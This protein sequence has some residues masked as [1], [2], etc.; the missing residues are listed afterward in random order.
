[1]RTMRAFAAERVE[2][3]KYSRRVGDPD[4]EDA[5]GG[6]SGGG[7]AAVLDGGSVSAAAPLRDGG[8][9]GGG[10]R[11]SRGCRGCGG[12]P[13]WPCC[14]ESS[15]LPSEESSY[16]LGVLKALGYGAFAGGMSLM[17]YASLLCVLW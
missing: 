8:R 12:C 15:W 3:L 10:S 2:F 1:M 6:R 17:G 9:G 16:K 5:K 11:G 13:G 4:R 14:G 7:P